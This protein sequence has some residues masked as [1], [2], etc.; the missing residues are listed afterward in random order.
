MKKLICALVVLA[1][2]GCA[3][4]KKTDSPEICRTK[5]RDR[6]QPHP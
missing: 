6:G 5:Q 4:C 3:V 1:L 2:A